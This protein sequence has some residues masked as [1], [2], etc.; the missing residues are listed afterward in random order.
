MIEIGGYFELE[1]NRGSEYHKDAIRLNSGRNAFEYILRSRKY[2]KVYLPYY[3]CDV[4]LEP[5]KKLKLEYE[6]YNINN[7]LEPVFAYE[8]LNAD[9]AF[10][11]TNYFGIKGSYLRQLSGICSNLIID[12]SQAFF[13]K[14]LTG[15]DTFYSPR[16]F[17]GL[18]DGAYLFTKKRLSAKLPIDNSTNRFSHLIKRID[19]GAKEGYID[20]KTNDESISGQPIKQMSKLT[21]TLLSSIDYEKSKNRRKKNFQFLNEHLFKSNKIKF[22]SENEFVPMVYP[23]WPDVGDALRNGLIKNNVF[24][25]RYWP[26]IN[27]CLKAGSIEIDLVKHLI[28]LPIDQRYG[29]KEMRYILK[30][31]RKFYA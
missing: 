4:M 12:N 8:G 6:F 20:F 16:K 28:P 24:V 29:L 31:I 9:Q 26:N 5:V 27:A 2:R 21:K 7:Q 30:V 25:A 23:Y 18:S 14:P 13:D 22:E 15:I 1:L 3:T 10:V 17:F 11:Y 19:E